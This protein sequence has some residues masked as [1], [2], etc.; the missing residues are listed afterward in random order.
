MTNLNSLNISRKKSNGSI[1]KASIKCEA[2]GS[3]DKLKITR[4]YVEEVTDEEEERNNE[5]EEKSFV[6][7]VKLPEVKVAR[8][9]SN[10]P[11][12]TESEKSASRQPDKQEV[13]NDPVNH[14]PDE[15]ELKVTPKIVVSNLGT[16]AG[17]SAGTKAL[18]QKKAR[19]GC[20]I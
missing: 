17:W 12:N 11:E 10:Q 13:L 4:V 3:H 2:E 8:K 6:D 14:L 20:P 1:V 5:P 16:N 19:N 15:K 18:S 9:G 7:E